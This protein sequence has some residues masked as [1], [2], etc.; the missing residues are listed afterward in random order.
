VLLEPTRIYVKSGLAAA[1]SGKVKAFAHITGG[2][3]IENIPRVLP[4]GTCAALDAARWELPV[5]FGWLAKTGR[6]A[7]EEM[8]RTFNC[9]VGMAVVTAPDLV[10]EVVSALDGAGETAFD[11]GRVEEGVRGCTVHG[12]AGTWGSHEDW[13]ATHNG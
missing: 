6:I 11:I 9:G 1:R 13:S 10:G 2:G 7:P 12:Q 3:L 8:A 4:D 5:V